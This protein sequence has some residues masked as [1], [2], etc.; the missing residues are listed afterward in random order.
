MNVE[1]NYMW[2]LYIVQCD[3]STKADFLLPTDWQVV[4]LLRAMNLA[5]YRDAFVR[6][7]VSGDILS[8]CDEKVLEEELGIH[9]KLHRMRLLHIIEGRR[10]ALALLAGNT[11]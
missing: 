11:S 9:N 4:E 5:Q 10:S 3:S 8:D 6:E 7:D 2:S 1:Y